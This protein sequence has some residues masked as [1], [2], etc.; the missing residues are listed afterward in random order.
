MCSWTAPASSPGKPCL[1][2]PFFPGQG[3]QYPGM[4]RDL[5]E[6]FPAARGVFDAADAALGFALS[7]VCFDG[8]A[9]E[10]QLTANTQPAILTVSAAASQVLADN[11]MKPAFVA[12]H[13]LR[14]VLCTC[15]FWRFVI[16]GC[17]DAGA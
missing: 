9:E 7:R 14:R 3:S 5:A 11:G 1:R 6:K 16:S 15:S 17:G 2:L 8:P 12:G 10:L 4:G 13:S